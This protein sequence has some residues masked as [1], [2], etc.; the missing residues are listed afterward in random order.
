L[1]F[2]VNAFQKFPDKCPGSSNRSNWKKQ[3]QKSWP[4]LEQYI[5]I[6]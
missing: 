4:F 3:T 2:V 5:R 1:F 6:Y